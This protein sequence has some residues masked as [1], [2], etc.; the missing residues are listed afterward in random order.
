MRRLIA[1]LAVPVALTAAGAAAGAPLT[2]S[3]TGAGWV[4]YANF[5]PGGSTT[6]LTVVS[7]RIVPTGEATGTIVIRSALGDLRA[8]VDCVV[9]AGDDVYVGG[10]V[11]Q[12]LD[13][14]GVV[15]THVAV[16]I[17]DLGPDGDV[18]A[19]AGFVNRPSGFD[20]CTP[21]TAFPPFWPA[22]PGNFVVSA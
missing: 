16:G 15:L 9:R 10:P 11:V 6:E 21:A 5:P 22:S 3:V 17:R 13:Y 12:G 7:A 1:F 19:G 18:V 20:A 14:G 8:Q 2:A 4:T